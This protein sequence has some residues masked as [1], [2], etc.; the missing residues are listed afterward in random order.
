[1]SFYEIRF[2]TNISYGSSGGPGFSTTI[3]G[4]DTGAE[5]RVSRWS[6][7]KRQY[8][9]SYGVKT[10]QDLQDVLEFYMSV[11]GAAYGFRYKDWI[12]F[13]TAS[14]GRS[15]YDVDSAYV[16]LYTNTTGVTIATNLSLQL[17][18][19]Y[20][21]TQDGTYG[22]TDVVIRN[23]TKPVFSKIK[24]ARSTDGSTFT[25]ITQGVGGWTVNTT[26]GI[27]TVSS[28]ANILA[29]ET[30]Y[31]AC[32]FDVPVRFTKSIDGL[33]SVSIDTFDTGNS[34]SIEL[35]EIVDHSEHFD[36]YF[37]GGS[38]IIAVDGDIT[39]TVGQGRVIAL[40]PA[41]ASGDKVILPD[42]FSLPTGGPYFYIVNRH[43]TRTM[44]LS[45]AREETSGHTS[46]QSVGASGTL[47][48]NSST[49]MWINEYSDGSR[50]WHRWDTNP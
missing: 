44:V 3:V 38:S 33:L 11:K 34:D 29:T 28:S 37:Y 42:P 47:A 36:E 50:Q 5:Q 6:K 8:D 21:V 40:D 41:N 15:S 2:P 35:V 31:G 10:F 49:T 46:Y 12:D 43:A 16:P 22:S 26:T 14:D 13:T 45:D 20:N 7:S 17:T 30:V 32:E 19:R 23:I 24:I 18:K 25:P 27:V 9:V 39:I 48:A 1:M 4:L